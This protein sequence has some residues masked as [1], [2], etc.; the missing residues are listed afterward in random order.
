MEKIEMGRGKI[1]RSTFPLSF[2]IERKEKSAL[3]KPMIVT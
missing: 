1:L 3:A 2:P